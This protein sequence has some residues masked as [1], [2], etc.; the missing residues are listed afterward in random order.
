VFVAGEG[1]E[2]DDADFDELAVHMSITLGFEPADGSEK[3][4]NQWIKSPRNIDAAKRKFLAVPFVRSL[5]AIPA[6]TI[7][8]C[9][10]HCG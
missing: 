5:V 1:E 3:G 7:T 6:R 9:V 4:S 2:D 8:I 10:D